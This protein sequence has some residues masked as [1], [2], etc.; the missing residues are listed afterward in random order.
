MV[1]G[2]MLYWWILRGFIRQSVYQAMSLWKL[3]GY[4]TIIK[5]CFILRIPRKSISFNEWRLIIVYFQHMGFSLFALGSI[6]SLF[7]SKGIH[8]AFQGRVSYG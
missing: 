2:L 3:G 5:Q 6:D 4:I 1:K 7:S 8:S